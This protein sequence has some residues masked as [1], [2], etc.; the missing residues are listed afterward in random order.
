MGM[1]IPGSPSWSWYQETV[2]L[3]FFPKGTL[4]DQLW[5]SCP[6]A[7]SSFSFL[8]CVFDDIISRPQSPRPGPG[9]TTALLPANVEGKPTIGFIAHLDTSPEISGANVPAPVVHFNGSD[10]P[11]NDTYVLSPSTF[12]NLLTY[13]GDDLVTPKKTPPSILPLLL[14]ETT[15]RFSSLSVS[16]PLQ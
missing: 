8:G 16:L 11:L 4:N 10:I 14:T 13:M 9:S 6:N 5:P 15:R 3:L 12:P 7:T 1:S 2:F